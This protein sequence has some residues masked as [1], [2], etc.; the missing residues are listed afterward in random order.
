[1]EDTVSADTR[2][3]VMLRVVNGSG[4]AVAVG[5]PGHTPRE[6]FARRARPDGHARRAATRARVRRLHSAA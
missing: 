6:R 5:Q 4:R 3:D 1:M 2:V